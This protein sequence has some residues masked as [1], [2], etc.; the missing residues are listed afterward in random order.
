M[1]GKLRQLLLD[2]PVETAFGREDFLVSPANQ[3]AWTTVEA[4]PRWPDT[5]LVLVGPPG[6]GK[7]HL[8]SIWAARAGARVLT[9]GVLPG[10]DLPAMAS[11]PAVLVEDADRMAG[12]DTAL[13]HLINLLRASGAS[14]LLTA[15]KHPDQ[16]GVSTA[17]LLSRLRLAPAVQIAPPDD[18][19]M[20]AVLVKHFVDRQ[21]IVDTALIEFL[22]THME[23]S[24]EA[25]RVTVEG[26]D[27]HALSLGRSITRQLAAEWLRPGESG[28]GD[29][30]AMRLA[31]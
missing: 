7:S 14:L 31:R 18:A 5:V 1:S 9:S 29:H 4:W 16:W 28:E 15:R 13:F 3:T 20:R 22:V 27:R 17:D 23:R 12:L 19:L 10:A 11:A 24:L 26:L 6:S 8:A 30:A 25:A 21:L 2:L